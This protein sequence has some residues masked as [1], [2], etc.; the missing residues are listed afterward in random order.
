MNYTVTWT[1]TLEAP[2]PYSAAYQALEM[3]QDHNNRAKI[4][5]VYDGEKTISF[6]LEKSIQL[7]IFT[8][9]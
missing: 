9:D 4:F 2:D 7:G 3:Q 8:E 6:D 5:D 1:V